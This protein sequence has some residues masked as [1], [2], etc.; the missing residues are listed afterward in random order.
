MSNLGLYGEDTTIL[1]A[2]DSVRKVEDSTWISRKPKYFVFE[3]IGGVKI[4]GKPV[5]QTCSVQLPFEED[6]HIQFD[7]L[8][9]VEKI[10]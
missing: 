4:S 6:Y 1:H 2:G 8:I 7:N 3:M 9:A 5:E 10:G